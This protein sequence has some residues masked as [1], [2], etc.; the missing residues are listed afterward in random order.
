MPSLSA[1]RENERITQGR[2]GTVE[3]RNT[4][5]TNTVM[6]KDD[7]MFPIGDLLTR[8]RHKHS[9]FRGGREVISTA[10]QMR[11]IDCLEM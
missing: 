11:S 5:E 1:T 9:N 7:I 3:I 4:L 6:V 2:I 10:I 8:P